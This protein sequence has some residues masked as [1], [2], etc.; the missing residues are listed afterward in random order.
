MRVRWL[1]AWLLMAGVAW[2][3]APGTLT[4]GM[5][6][7]PPDMHPDISATSAKFYVEYAALRPVISFDMEGGVICVLCT[8]VP[9]R[10]NGLA[11]VVDLP[12]GGK[13]M[14]VTFHLRSDIFWGDGVPVTAA[15]VAFAQKVAHAFGETPNVTEVKAEG[16]HTVLVR[17]DATRYDYARLIPMPLPEHIEGKIFAAAKTPLEYGRASAYNTDPPNPGLWNGPYRIS[18]FVGNQSITLVPNE[19]WKG[20]KP[21]WREIGTRL[22]ENTA[23]LQA[24]ALSGDVDMI[25][26]ALG[27]TVNQAITMQKNYPARFTYFYEPTLSY[28]HLAL[29]LDNPLLAD[30]RVR[31]ALL[32]AIDR[33]TIVNKLFGGVQPVAQSFLAPSQFGWHQDTPTWPFDVAEAK[34]KLA[35]AGFKPGSDGILVSP[36]GERFEITLTTTTGNVQRELVEQVLQ[37]EFKVIGVKLN[38]R[39]EPARTMF[40]ETLR[41]R[42][43][44]GMVMF[45]SVPPPDNVPYDAFASSTIPAAANNW[46]GQ[47]YMGYRNPAMDAALEAARTELDPRKRYE[48]WKTILDIYATDLPELPLFFVAEPYIVPRTIT[49]ILPP[50]MRSFATM[51]IEDW[52]PAGGG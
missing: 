17:L 29:N 41:K 12:G 3:G 1:A 39:N 19:Y 52:R 46:F 25:S 43:F 33:R 44:T 8:E 47:N 11:K 45:T 7:F 36:K 14:E 10:G 24:N 6:Q 48:D 40:G 38:I 21:A 51:W 34:R 5:S 2:A 49:G 20:R 13:G 50:R 32:M 31:Q 18:K 22:L 9:T 16:P 35:E 30:R 42:N 26:S 37:S 27:L 23:A 4:I 15:D 28:E